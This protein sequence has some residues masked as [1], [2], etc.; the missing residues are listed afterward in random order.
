MIQ[1]M[2]TATNYRSMNGHFSPHRANQ[3]LLFD[4]GDTLMRVFPQYSGA[5]SKWPAVE[6]MPHAVETLNQLQS[7][8]TL[9]LATNAADSQE[10]DIR[11]ALA[12]VGL[13]ILIDQ[14]YCFRKVGYKKPLP[15]FFEYILRDLGMERS[16]VIM[17]GDDFEADVVG[18][19]QIGIR[20]VWVNPR[21][22]ESKQMNQ[23]WI[24][25]DLSHLLK[26]FPTPA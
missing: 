3:A 4:W 14:V 13:D 10:A 8:W 26:I 6:A 9:C 7:Y 23:Y 5:M 24:I 16:Q 21:T 25:P 20:A 18:A 12:R 15:E 19:Y 11:A 17:I 1:K 2:S 22:V